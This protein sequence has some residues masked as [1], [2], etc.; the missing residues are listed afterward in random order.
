MNTGDN[1]YITGTTTMRELLVVADQLAQTSN[2]KIKGV[3]DPQLGKTEDQAAAEIRNFP[4]DAR[5]D[6]RAMGRCLYRELADVQ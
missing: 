3:M 4:A 5:R 1:T 2:P 6:D